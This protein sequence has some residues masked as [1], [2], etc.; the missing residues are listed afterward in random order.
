MVFRN[1]V[2]KIGP[3]K[4]ILMTLQ[5]RICGLWLLSCLVCSAVAA[6]PAPDDPKTWLMRAKEEARRVR[7]RREAVLV[8]LGIADASREAGDSTEATDAL[9][10][11]ENAAT[12]FMNPE[13]AA[14]VLTLVAEARLAEGDLGKAKDLIRQTA[15]TAGAVPDKYLQARTL[16]TCAGLSKRAGDEQGWNE[17]LAAAVAIPEDEIRRRINERTNKLY[18]VYLRCIA[19]AAAI[20]AKKALESIQECDLL[21][22]RR[23]NR[24]RPSAFLATGYARV[25]SA[26]ARSDVGDVDARM[27]FE[28][29]YLG[30]CHF[31]ADPWHEKENC[32][33]YLVEA[34][35]GV[36]ATDRAW[37]GAINLPAPEARAAA[38]AAVIRR[39]LRSGAVERV[40]AML[41]FLPADSS[42]VSVFRWVG[43][44]Q[45]QLEWQPQRW[46]EWLDRLRSPAEKSLGLA[47]L[48]AGVARGKRPD[49]AGTEDDT[50]HAGAS[51]SVDDA[52][53]LAEA[54]KH[55]EATDVAVRLL[56]TDSDKE[57]AKSV[58]QSSSQ[59]SPEWWL[60][61]ALNPAAQVKDARARA[62]LCVEIAR[63]CAKVSQTE[64]YRK[65]IAQTT[66]AVLDMWA[67]VAAI[68]QTKRTYD[69]GYDWD[70][71]FRKE[72]A[73][74]AG[75]EAIL[76]V[77]LQIEA[78]Q[79]Q[80][81]DKDGAFRTLL[82]A[83]K[84]ADLLPRSTGSLR[85]ATP[86][87]VQIWYAVLAGRLRSL[88]Q[89]EAAKHM[90]DAANL[91][92]GTD[93]GRGN[94]LLTAL[95]AAENGELDEV[96][97]LAAK[98]RKE[99]DR[100]YGIRIYGRLARLAAA[101]DSKEKFRSA[102]FVVTGLLRDNPHPTRID[103]A[104]GAILLGD[105]AFA[106]E[107]LDAC[108]NQNAE[109]AMARAALVRRL[110]EEDQLEDGRQ[111]A[112]AIN[113]P[114][115]KTL[116]DLWLTKGEAQKAAN[117][118]YSFWSRTQSDADE[119]KKA[120]I[121]AGVAAAFVQSR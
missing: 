75:V 107:T 64:L 73:F 5:Q 112:S 47:G 103:I 65:A 13:Q 62:L 44:A 39:E 27:C 98:I 77:L 96:E 45:T 95:E 97:T 55:R 87:S 54:G 3:M 26:V 36:R 86:G 46:Q 11:A 85:E 105:T 12:S 51:A 40:G 119:S 118:L 6:Q 9:A 80:C 74:A 30:A 83:V 82:L 121:L 57:A 70:T 32:R 14:E 91:A 52:R 108:G 20:D 4:G 115:A 114:A 113:D 76:E 104:H 102:V 78:V 60:T 90:F 58:F 21:E 72:K 41:R 106:Q 66:H 23:D 109:A 71:D 50:S 24:G 89:S 2:L 53:R 10:S 63:N 84:S 59:R 29:S 1:R 31:L 22:R 42:A 25:A 79:R 92:L 116:A 117:D 34:D 67:E 93:Y 100:E 81:D 110:V 7:D 35:A 48:A 111:V 99:G 38:M 61:R 88:R 94:L 56:E 8:W 69:G 19:Y 49:T 28:P 15:S 101:Q 37:V 33:S 43:E 120:A 17:H 18:V 16:A 68:R